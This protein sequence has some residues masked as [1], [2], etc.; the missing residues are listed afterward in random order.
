M[1]P[2]WRRS[3]GFPS[4]R[5]FAQADKR[6][7]A[8]PQLVEDLDRVDERPRKAV[9]SAADQVRVTTEADGGRYALKGRALGTD[10]PARWRSQAA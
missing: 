3:L 2:C 5:T 10:Q 1:R 6:D 4:D 9:E 7:A 8:M